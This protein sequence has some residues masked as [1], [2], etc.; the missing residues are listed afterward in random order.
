[1]I[2]EMPS[3]LKVLR[4]EIVSLPSIS[5][6]NQD[7]LCKLDNDSFVKSKAK[8]KY[9]YKR[10]L[11]DS[12]NDSQNLSK[13]NA[14][15]REAYLQSMKNIFSEFDSPAIHCNSYILSRHQE[16]KLIQ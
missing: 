16:C 9:K 5:R 4:N 12:S 1:M 13:I 7:S 3:E 2:V 14:T 6:Y 15:S 10:M 8:S 11:T